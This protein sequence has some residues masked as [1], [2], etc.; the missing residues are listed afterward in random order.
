ARAVASRTEERTPTQ[1]SSRTP[2][3]TPEHPHQHTVTPAR[4][5][6]RANFATAPSRTGSLRP[7]PSRRSDWSAT[8]S[9]THWSIPPS[10][11]TRL[12]WSTN[13][14]H[15]AES[16]TLNWPHWNTWTGTTTGASTAPATALL[17]LKQGRSTTVI[18]TRYQPQSQQA[19]PPDVPGR[20]DV[21]HYPQIRTSNFEYV[22][23]HV[24][25][26][27]ADAACRPSHLVLQFLLGQWAVL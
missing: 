9:I 4:V 8:H 7:G 15:G 26:Q 2:S 11:C 5:S 23:I 17:P 22:C 12:N 24:I 19:N 14:V 1:S 18:T 16:T 27:H 6:P 25:A 10:G 21:G 20:F 13:T 3:P